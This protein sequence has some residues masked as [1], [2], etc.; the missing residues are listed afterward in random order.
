MA[1][2]YVVSTATGA[3]DGTSEA[4]A[5][6]TI[7]AAF[8]EPT[9]AGGDKIWVKATATYSEQ[10]NIDTEGSATAPI[11]VEGYTSTEGDNGKVT[12]DGGSN[13]ITDTPSN[14]YYVFKNFIFTGASSH[15]VNVANIYAFL[16]CDFKDNG[17][18]GISG[19]NYQMFLNCTFTGNSVEGAQMGSNIYHRY[20]GCVFHTN[21]TEAASSVGVFDV[22]YKCVFYANGASSDVIQGVDDTVVIGCTFDGDNTSGRIIDANIES[23]AVIVDNIFHD[24]DIA[25]YTTD[26]TAQSGLVPGVIGYNLLSSLD[27]GA[28]RDA[29]SDLTAKY[30]HWGYG[31]VTSAPGFTDEAGD[32]YKLNAAS[33]ARGAG[34]KPGGIT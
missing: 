1:E 9:L 24:A 15:G 26:T 23:A 2:W 5:F 18:N 14:N 31:D 17:G 29:S 7:D 28:Y 13:C 32:D 21:A 20:I 16:N 6:T 10:A 4:D 8:S 19:G 25:Y 3:G 34:L 27:T 11:V 12:I 30:E 33:P 22:Y